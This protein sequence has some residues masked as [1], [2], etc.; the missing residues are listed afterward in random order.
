MFAIRNTKT[1]KFVCGTD[2][3]YLP[4]HQRTS[5]EQLLTYATL[6]SVKR[7]FIHRQCGGD[8]YIVEIDAP[9]VRAVVPKQSG[10]PRPY[11]IEDNDW[12]RTT[13]D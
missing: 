6:A 3:R 1:G 4:H 13:V 7:D 10:A 8:Y 5:S 11:S 2:Y 12:E 9:V